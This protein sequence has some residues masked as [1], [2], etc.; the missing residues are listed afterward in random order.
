MT[1][2]NLWQEPLSDPKPSGRLGELMGG[3]LERCSA[4]C[5]SRLFALYVEPSHEEPAQVR[6]NREIRRAPVSEYSLSHRFASWLASVE[7][8]QLRRVA[9][10]LLP[11]L[12]MHKALVLPLR[13]EGKFL[14]ALVLEPTGL[15]RLEMDYLL[16]QAAAL[17]EQ[18]SRGARPARPRADSMTGFVVESMRRIKLTPLDEA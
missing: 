14:G 2:A 8:P 9:T 15:S 16:S 6:L 5:P 18:L 11:W 12:P 13:A 17:A 1:L 4:A 10:F 3:C 7:A